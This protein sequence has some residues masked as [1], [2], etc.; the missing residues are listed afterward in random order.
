MYKLCRF[1]LLFHTSNVQ[2][3]KRVIYASSK[4]AHNN[5]AISE[6]SEAI[7]KLHNSEVP[8]MYMPQPCTSAVLLLTDLT[9]TDLYPDFQ[10][11]KV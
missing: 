2:S 4:H 9:P 3:L 6:S 11:K 10:I 8:A 7:R 5:T 1:L